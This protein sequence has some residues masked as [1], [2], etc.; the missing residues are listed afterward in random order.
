MNSGKS[1]RKTNIILIAA[2]CTVTVLMTVFA[3]LYFTS[4]K[5]DKPAEPASTAGNPVYVDK[6]KVVMVPDGTEIYENQ[7]NFFA[8]LLLE[9]EDEVIRLSLLDESER[10]A[11]LKSSLE[12]FTREYIYRLHEANRLGLTVPDNTLAEIQN[13]L[14]AEY[15]DYM[16]T[17]TVPLS[18]AEFIKKLYGLTEEQYEGFWK[19]WALVDIYEK[20]ISESADTSE[21]S[22]KNAYIKYMDYLFSYDCKVLSLSL[23]GLNDEKKKEQITFARELAERIKSGY[24]MAALVRK[25]CEDSALSETDGDVSITG[26]FRNSFPEIYEW[27][28]SASV[29]DT[30][31][32]V[33]DSAIYIVKLLGYTEFEQLKGTDSMLEWTKLYA[34]D[35]EVNSLLT[36]DRYKCTVNSDV[37]GA[38]DFTQMINRAIDEWSKYWNMADAED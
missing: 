16:K 4:A 11:S 26:Y 32:V 23:E 8:T 2:L 34:V 27:V 13:S 17:E 22:Q 14:E 37:F 35:A 36:G 9:Q 31:T 29:G 12:S 18:K 6:G 5:K 28:S 21:E 7:I 1:S 24:D 3:V 15:S 38:M 25:Y 33:S 19:D 20:S 10:N 30:G